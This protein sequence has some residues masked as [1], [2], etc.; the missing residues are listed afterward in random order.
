MWIDSLEQLFF[1][2]ALVYLIKFFQCHIFLFRQSCMIVAVLL[3][4]CLLYSFCLYQPYFLSGIHKVLISKNNFDWEV[5]CSG[6]R[7][8]LNELSAEEVT[9]RNEGEDDNP[10]SGVMGVA[11]PSTPIY[12]TSSGQYSKNLSL[13]LQPLVASLLDRC[14][15]LYLRCA[16]SVCRGS[17]QDASISYD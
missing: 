6:C 17:F 9:S 11:V 10:A 5:P 4:E 15:H 16:S 7:K 2:V 3:C 12:Q 13:I 14:I 8:I 1:S